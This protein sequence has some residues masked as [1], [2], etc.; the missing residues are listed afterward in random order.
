MNCIYSISIHCSKAIFIFSSYIY[1]NQKENHQKP[2]TDRKKQAY[3]FCGSLL[4]HRQRWKA[5]PG[6]RARIYAPPFVKKNLTT[7]ALQPGCDE[8][9]NQYYS[10]ICMSHTSN[11]WNVYTVNRFAYTNSSFQCEIGFEED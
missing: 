7:W 3:I 5:R 1:S 8:R 9:E 6:C 11:K 10:N 2:Q 4:S